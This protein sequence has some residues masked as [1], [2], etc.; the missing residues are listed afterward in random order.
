MPQSFQASEAGRGDYTSPRYSE[1]AAETEKERGDFQSQA[2]RKEKQTPIRK[3]P[4]PAKKKPSL[5]ISCC[6]PR[7]DKTASCI[8]LEDPEGFPVVLSTHQWEI[9][10][11]FCRDRVRALELEGS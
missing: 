4:P 11:L 5:P 9:M 6:R 10:L 1:G 8:H 3:R 7:R 2:I